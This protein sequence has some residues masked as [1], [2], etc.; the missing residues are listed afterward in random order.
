MTVTV[1]APG[2][3]SMTLAP[4]SLHAVQGGKASAALSL[5]PLN[6][7]GGTVVLSASA[8]PAGVTAAFASSNSGVLVQFTVSS[9]AAAAT[10]PVNL[11][12]TSGTL[13]HTAVL[14]LTVVAPTAGTALVDLSPYYNVSGIAVDNV[15]FTSGGLDGGGRSYSGMLLGASQTVS[16]TVFALGPMGVPDAVSGQTVT[17]P[18]GKFT[19]LKLLATGINSNQTSQRFTVT[20]TDGTTTAITQSMSDWFTPQNYAGES[21][22]MTMNYRDNSTATTEG[23]AFHL[24]GYSFALNNAKTVRS[25]T[26]PQNR[27]IVVLAMTLSTK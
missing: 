5:A 25:I 4:N 6:G 27:N 15:P 22:A 1:T 3:F 11:T 14:N 18:S 9:A 10:T 21:Q 24:Y 23:A 2:D 19:A 13:V 16:G 20:Y 7:F 12:A 8:V 26:L 17:L